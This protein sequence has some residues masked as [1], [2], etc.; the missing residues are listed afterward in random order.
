MS[1][2]NEGD[3]LGTAFHE[4]F[5]LSRPAI[6]Q[7]LQYIASSGEDKPSFD[8]LR[9]GT[10]LGTNYIKSMRRYSRGAGLVDEHERLTTFGRLVASMDATLSNPITM[11]LLHYFLSSPHHQGPPFWSALVQGLLNQQA[12][13]TQSE[14]A[15]D[16]SRF[17]ESEGEKQL[18]ERTL[19]TTA[20]VF[21]GTY[22]KSDGLG[23]LGILT[24]VPRSDRGERCF[25]IGEE[26]SLAP[27]LVAVFV[28]ADYW[29]HAWPQF[30]EV[31]LTSFSEPTGPGA[32]LLMNSGEV[33]DVLKEMQNLGLVQLQRRRAPY[34]VFRTWDDTTKI[35]ERVYE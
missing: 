12:Q 26:L 2:A 7:V 9:E 14:I 8:D 31:N 19:Q 24:E 10:T 16:I 18:A 1:T 6:S 17:L 34:Q 29:D 15:A 30:K 20:T 13:I 25:D 32:L 28:I 35:L 22:V 3:R 4:S 27:A 23:P 5:S 33:A 11:W 21:A